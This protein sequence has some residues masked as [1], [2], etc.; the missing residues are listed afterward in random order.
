MKT[1][2]LGSV[3]LMG[4]AIA[5]L[6]VGAAATLK[7]VDSK[8]PNAT[9]QNVVERGTPQSAANASRAT[10]RAKQLSVAF[11]EAAKK[12]L[13]A[14]VAIEN[15][16]KPVATQSSDEGSARNPFGDRNP[17]KGTPFEKEF[18]N[19]KFESPRRAPRRG[20]L[21]SGV[22]IDRSGL[23]LTNNHVVAGGGDVTVRLNDGREFP[24]T[25]V[26]TDPKTDIAVV[27]IN[28]SNLTAA[29]LGN[30]DDMEIGDWVLALGQ[31]FGL[32][33]TVTAGI[34]SAKHRGIGI[35]ARENFLQTDAAINP[36]NSGGPLVNLDGQVI[37]I[38]TAITSRGGGNDGV[39]FAVPINLAKW[40]ADQLSHG[41]VVHRAFLGV[42]I[43][44]MTATLAK[45]FRVSPHDGVVV[46]EIRAGS[47]ASKG[48]LKV[49]DVIVEVAGQKIESPQE[50]QLAIERS[51]VGKPQ[52][53]TVVREGKR[54]EVTF[55]PAAQSAESS[56]A[57]GSSNEPSK[58][59][60][61][62][63]ERLGMQISDLTADVAKQLGLQGVEGV[64]I[65]D[66][67]SDSPADRAGL[68]SG[69]VIT[70]INRKPVKSASDANRI[71][72]DA[73]STGDV[74]LLVR[75]A[76]GARFVVV[77]S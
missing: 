24:A 12:V 36:G 64:V 68:K 16:P 23:I 63:L 22:V 25:N 32:E 30:S 5:S 42:G 48:G 10:S 58:A 50:L 73:S 54:M 69:Q 62:R 77:K 14:V 60:S 3:L 9:V 44:P 26:W 76:E 66:V 4:A 75:S 72:K 47:P 27:K 59:T 17:F 70:Q 13:P 37:G 8:R 61:S 11:R 65:T 15:R 35:T 57:S 49:G 52:R 29:E 21:G 53:M 71:L 38:N 41:G 34:I 39:G 55:S 1:G 7:Q 40:V 56:A 18:K 45:Q 31:P 46:T 74:L 19:F 33:S 2:I 43:Q 28:A 67:K 51:P 6:A 20:G